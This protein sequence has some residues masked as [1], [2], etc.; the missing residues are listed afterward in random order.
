MLKLSRVKK[1]L[2]RLKMANLY[3]QVTP[4][5]LSVIT[6]KDHFAVALKDTRGMAENICLLR[7]E[8]FCRY[9]VGHLF[10]LRQRARR[11]RGGRRHFRPRRQIQIP[12]SPR[13]LITH[14]ATSANLPY[15]ARGRP[16]VP[17]S[18][19]YRLRIF[20]PRAISLPLSNDKK[21]Q[22]P[23]AQIQRARIL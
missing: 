5:G 2:G 22:R 17:I 11:R 9:A 20:C 15:L 8:P 13:A 6:P 19:P 18:Y 3:P 21:K 23:P 12:R 1:M 10:R 7:P 4:K 16:Q 14:F